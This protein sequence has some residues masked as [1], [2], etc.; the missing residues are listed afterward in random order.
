MR[1]ALRDLFS[2][3][4]TYQAELINDAQCWYFV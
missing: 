1:K 2:R 4:F 3:E